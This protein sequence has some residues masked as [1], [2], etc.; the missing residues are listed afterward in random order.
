VLSLAAGAAEAA[1]ASARVRGMPARVS[2][3]TAA[4]ATVI[5]IVKCFT[6]TTPAVPVTGTDQLKRF[7][8]MVRRLAWTQFPIS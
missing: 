4:Q 5:E 6:V 7:D 1:A 2:S 3:T 8:L